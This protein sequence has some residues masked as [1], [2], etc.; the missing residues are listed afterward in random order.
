[1]FLF[2]I[3]YTGYPRNSPTFKYTTFDI[4]TFFLF[5]PALFALAL[6]ISLLQTNPEQR[7]I[8]AQICETNLFVEYLGKCS[9]AIYIFQILFVDFYYATIVERI[10]SGVFPWTLSYEDGP[11]F[12]NQFWSYGQPWWVTLIG[13][14]AT[15]I[16]CMVIQLQFQEKWVMN[17]YTRATERPETQAES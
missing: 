7:S 4:I 13:V 16:L 5:G 12:A 8:W 2:V 10:E 1:V 11:F 9:L 3:F 14:L 6:F 17:M 15:V